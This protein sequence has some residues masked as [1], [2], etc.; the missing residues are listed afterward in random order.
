MREGGEYL[1]LSRCA[2]FNHKDPC[3]SKKEVEISVRRDMTTEEEVRLL[4]EGR[5]GS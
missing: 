4:K 1:G 5:I 3:K 2:Q